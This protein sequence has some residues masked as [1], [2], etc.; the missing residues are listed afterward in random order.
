MR[1]HRLT[2]GHYRGIRSCQLTFA[3]RGVTVVEGDNEAGKSSAAEALHLLI[4]YRDDSSR[5]EVRAVKPLHLD[6]GAEVE[7]EIS[8]G[9]LR[10]TYAKRWHRDRYTRLRITSPRVEVMTG[11]DAHDRVRALLATSVDLEL[12]RALSAPQASGLHQAAL[13]DHPSLVAALDAVAGGELGT[14]E[15]G[16]LLK[17][18]EEEAARWFTPLGKAKADLL[19]LR[20]RAAAATAELDL[21]RGALLALDED[22]RSCTELERRAHDVA[23]ELAVTTH[24]A[25]T[26]AAHVTVLR[27]S[28]TAVEALAVRARLDRTRAELAHSAVAQRTSLVKGEARGALAFEAARGERDAAA[29]VVAT[30]ELVRT[31]A[32]RAVAEAVRTSTVTGRGAAEAEAAESEMREAA[33][34]AEVARQLADVEQLLEAATHLQH[35][36]DEA[37]SALSAS[38]STPAALAAVQEAHDDALRAEAALVAGRASVRIEA[39]RD[40]TI[41]VDGT[42]ERFAAATTTERGVADG[43][44]LE[45]ADE[46]RIT[47]AAGPVVGGLEA[48]HRATAALV[49]QRCEALGVTGLAGARVLE[50]ERRALVALV[51]GRRG[52][53]SA[54]LGRSTVAELEHLAAQA[55]DVLG[56]R[57]TAAPPDAPGASALAAARARLDEARREHHA[58]QR[59]A[60]RATGRS[61]L[62]E[63]GARAALTALAGSEAR[64]VAARHQLEGQTAALTTAREEQPDDELVAS[65]EAAE[66][67]SSGATAAWHAGTADIDEAELERVERSASKATVDRNAT[68]DALAH[69]REQ[70]AAVRSRLELQGEAGLH[71]RVAEAERASAAVAAELTAVEGRGAAARLLLSTLTRHRDTA[72]RAYGAPL[73]VELERLGRLVFGPTFGVEL[74][75]ELRVSARLL[76]GV[77]VPWSEL[78]VGAKEQ[79]AVLMRLAAATIVSPEGGVPVVFDDVLGFTDPGRLALMSSAFEAAAEH[80]QIIVLTCDPA[81]Y[82]HLAR[83]TTHCL[84][85]SWDANARR[86]G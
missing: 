1:V 55:R 35:Q 19:A 85:A 64:L 82:R 68:A 11:R 45:L 43:L 38:R 74:D 21:R 80:C 63:D 18:A 33:T 65:W 78:S 36:L 9:S 37:E 40:L 72:A 46:V 61:D 8:I 13:R 59:S 57:G 39:L 60:D 79:L 47:I 26:T 51:R 4:E 12:W 22:V 49:T 7:A 56:A 44:V 27:A 16:D 83:A 24:A 86:A 10:F 75:D 71:D 15:E 73:R 2:L 20:Q 53:L 32:A 50:D 67:E 42:V 31:E 29:V 3:E 62:A 41:G 52:A 5:R 28:H 23:G 81:R 14:P 76:D 66:Q 6:A 84:T 34:V 70:L 77:P 54:A 48:R 58:S 69:L 30:A 25:H 17:R